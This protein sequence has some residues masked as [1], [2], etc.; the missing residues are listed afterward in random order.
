MPTHDSP[1]F[2]IPKAEILVPLP[3]YRGEYGWPTFAD[4]KPFLPSYYGT[5]NSDWNSWDITN[6]YAVIMKWESHHALQADLKKWEEES[7]QISERIAEE[8]KKQF[9]RQEQKRIA[10]VNK[11]REEDEKHAAKT[12]ERAEQLVRDR[13]DEADRR[14]RADAIHADQMEAARKKIDLEF[15]KR[16]DRDIEAAALLVSEISGRIPMLMRLLEK[17]PKERRHETGVSFLLVNLEHLKFD[18]R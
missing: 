10:R 12:R 17:L 18:N 5:L 8:E 11:Q 9:D 16:I 6:K 2:V 7:N 3:N 13:E 1:E 4:I 14:K 15:I